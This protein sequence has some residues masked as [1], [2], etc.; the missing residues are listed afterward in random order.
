MEIVTKTFGYLAL[1]LFVSF[2]IV[3]FISYKVEKPFMQKI[4]EGIAL[5]TGASIV[6]YIFMA[7][8]TSLR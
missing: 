5:A 1:T 3:L 2:Y 4:L 6:V 7:I 8:F